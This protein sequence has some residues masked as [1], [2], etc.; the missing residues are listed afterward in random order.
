MANTNDLVYVVSEL[1]K[2]NA[3]MKELG[4]TY[5]NLKQISNELIDIS[6]HLEVIQNWRMGND[7]IDLTEPI[8]TST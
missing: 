3:K 2:F 8:I 4:V 7:M 5:E 1:G 6:H